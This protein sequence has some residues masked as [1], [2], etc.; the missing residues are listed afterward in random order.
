MP[1]G[2]VHMPSTD[3]DSLGSNAWVIGGNHTFHGK[4]ILANDPHLANMIPSLF[5]M[6]EMILVDENN[7]TKNQGFGLM[8]DGVPSLSIG[9]NKNFAW[10]S[11][12]SYVDN[13]DVFHEKVR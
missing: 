5:Y 3:Y 11:T 4:P 10:G 7:N 6:I 12:A 2:S 8:V 1:I 13:K 9:I